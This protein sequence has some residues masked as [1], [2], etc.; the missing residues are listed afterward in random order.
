MGRP[1][2]RHVRRIMGKSNFEFLKETLKPS[3]R[4]RME[5]LVKLKIR[6]NEIF[7][8]FLTK[9]QTFNFLISFLLQ[10]SDL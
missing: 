8:I 5:M 1:H 6:E 3:I 7:P 2:E 9:L 4:V 10:V